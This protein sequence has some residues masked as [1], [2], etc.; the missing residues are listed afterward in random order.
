M[1]LASTFVVML[2]L[3]MASSLTANDRFEDK[4]YHGFVVRL[5]LGAATVRTDIPYYPKDDW[6]KW[7]SSF[8]GNFGIGLRI[9]G[10]VLL[11]F[12]GLYYAFEVSDNTWS[13]LGDGFSVVYYLKDEFY[14]EAGPFFGRLEDRSNLSGIFDRITYKDGIG[15]FVVAGLDFPI[16][17]RWSLL[18]S[19]RFHYINFDDFESKI[20]AFSIGIGFMP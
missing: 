16:S 11:M 13:I 19:L 12:E 15:M 20:V 7:R 18:P 5:D 4:G 1:K 6:N 2:L 14:L 17:K 8:A 10:N 9:G 3:F